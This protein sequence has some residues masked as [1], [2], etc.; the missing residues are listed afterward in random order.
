MERIMIGPNQGVQQERAINSSS[1][2][3]SCPWGPSFCRVEDIVIRRDWGIQQ[4]GAIN[5]V[6]TP[7]AVVAAASIC[8]ILDGH[9]GVLALQ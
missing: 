1:A 9:E 2:P 6:S 3:R 7:L 5:S 8:D 4:E